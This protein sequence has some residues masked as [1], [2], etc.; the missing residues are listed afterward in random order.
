MNPGINSKGV[1]EL[2]LLGPIKGPTSLLLEYVNETLPL[3][4]FLCASDIGYCYL[5]S[6]LAYLKEETVR[7]VGRRGRGG[8][9]R[10]IIILKNTNV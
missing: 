6:I 10:G 4:L 2:P 7:Y 5:V 3:M 8:R 9:E 1:Q